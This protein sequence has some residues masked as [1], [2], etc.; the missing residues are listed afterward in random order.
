MF[1]IKAFRAS[2]VMSLHKQAVEKLRAKHGPR[3]ARRH[4]G[5]SR[6]DADAYREAFG[7]YA[8]GEE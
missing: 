8:E 5:D 4:V 3:G 1:D 7:E 6:R 2:F